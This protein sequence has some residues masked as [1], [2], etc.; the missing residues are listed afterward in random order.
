MN[1][2]VFHSKMR[3][4]MWVR[5]VQEELRVDERSWWIFPFRS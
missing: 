5:S 1:S 4:L 3:A 2:L